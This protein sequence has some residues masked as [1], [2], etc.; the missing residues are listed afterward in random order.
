MSSIVKERK[1]ETD[2]QKEL[3]TLSQP[4]CHARSNEQQPHAHILNESST[5][6]GE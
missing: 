2:R 6:D 5:G 4:K 3:A 1:R